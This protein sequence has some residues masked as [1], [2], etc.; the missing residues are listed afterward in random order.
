M[1]T[2]NGYIIKPNPLSPTLWNIAVE[3]RG[4]KIP[5]TMEGSFTTLQY[6]MDLIDKHNGVKKGKNDNQAN[7]TE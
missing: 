5:K 6:A 3:G 7:A 2:Y 1:K 4:G